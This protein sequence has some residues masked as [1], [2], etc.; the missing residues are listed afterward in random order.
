[1][2]LPCTRSLFEH[3]EGLLIRTFA[4]TSTVTGPD[5]SARQSPVV[6]GSAVKEADC[7]DDV[8]NDQLPSVW[9]STWA[10][11]WD[12]VW[13]KILLKIVIGHALPQPGLPFA[14]PLRVN[15]LSSPTL[16]L[17]DS[18]VVVTVRPVDEVGVAVGLAE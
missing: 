16:V 15:P 9:V 2:T 18:M 14:R 8:A 1:V 4:L 3:D 17:F 13:P 12:W 6:L 11:S 10:T 7:C 5:G